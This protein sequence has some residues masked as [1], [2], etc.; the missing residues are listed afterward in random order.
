MEQQKSSTFSSEES[1]LME[2]IQQLRKEQR[3]DLST[4]Q[5]TMLEKHKMSNERTQSLLDSLKNN[6]KIFTVEQKGLVVYM[7]IQ[8]RYR[9]KKSRNIENKETSLMLTRCVK[10][11]TQ[12]SIVF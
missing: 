6:A 8:P 10:D 2:C 3:S 11:L 5:S 12:V 1:S 4:I 9:M 7:T